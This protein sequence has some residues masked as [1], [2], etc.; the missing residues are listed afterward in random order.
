MSNNIQNCPPASAI[1]TPGR[2]KGYFVMCSLDR[3][4]PRRVQL[5]FAYR[6]AQISA[7]PTSDATTAAKAKTNQTRP[8]QGERNWFFLG[9]TTLTIVEDALKLIER[10][11]GVKVVVETL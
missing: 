2:G 9:L 6:I 1:L 4:H 5:F 8:E 7:P 11:R 3:R 10:H